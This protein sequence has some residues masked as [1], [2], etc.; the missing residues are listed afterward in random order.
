MVATLLAALAG[1]GSAGDGPSGEDAVPAAETD[2]EVRRY[3]I[4]ADEV[5]WD[6]APEGTNLITG[7]PFGE[8]E[9][10]FVASGPQ[11][12]GSVYTKSVFREYT[13]ETF[14]ELKPRPEEW[15]HLGIMGP[16]IHAEVGDRVEVVLRNNTPFPVSL[17][18]HGLRYAK[19]AE[20]SPYADGTTGDDE[21]DD[22]VPQGGTYTYVWEVPERAGPGPHDPSSMMWMYHSHVDEVADVY[23]GLMGP[24]IVTREGMARPDGS[25]ED[26][27]REFVANFTVM[28]EN[29]SR[30]LDRNIE[31]A[32]KPG[33]VDREDEDFLESNLMHAINGYVYGNLPG[34][35]MERGEKIRWYVMGMGTEVDLHTPHWHGNTATAGGMR[36]DVVNILPASMVIAD[37]EPDVAG[38]WQFHCHVAD[39]ITAGMQALYEVR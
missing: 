26:V 37:M 33:T 17:H 14:S 19:D 27:D 18:P 9:N 24:I 11:Q 20:G 23:T 21:A 16:P 25:P 31:R 36:T 7:E 4:A 2:R 3:Y 8:D 5:E 29:A 32:G 1:C 10:V 30:W 13:D 35:T 28:D 34:L 22:A 39:H 6:Y 38:T 15:Q 12:I